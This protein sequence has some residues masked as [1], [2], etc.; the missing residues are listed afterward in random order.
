LEFASFVRDSTCSSTD[1]CFR[2]LTKFWQALLRTLCR[3]YDKFMTTPTWHMG[4]DFWQNYDKSCLA[5]R[6]I[7]LTHH[8]KS[9]LSSCVRFCLLFMTTLA[10][11]MV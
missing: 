3:V 5:H 4:S 11:H 6:I 10:G 7:F 2:F 1:L 9:C 8:D